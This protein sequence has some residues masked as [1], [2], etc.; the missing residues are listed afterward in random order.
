MSAPI[1]TQTAN[2]AMTA[3]LPPKHISRMRRAT[4][5]SLVGLGTIVGA[6]LSF[7]FLSENGMRIAEW[8]LLA[9]FIPLYYQLNV[10][11]WTAL[12]GVWLMN[13]PKPDSLSLWRRHT[14]AALRNAIRRPDY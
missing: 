14:N 5:F 8:G 2:S 12:F 9:V 6:W 3:G 13:R 1:G 4:F 11:F 7:I 10:G